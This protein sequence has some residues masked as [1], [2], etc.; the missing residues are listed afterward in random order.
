MLKSK[1]KDNISVTGYLPHHEMIDIIGTAKAMVLAANEDLGLTCLE[2]QSCG[3]PVIALKKGGY[4]ETV[5]EG[6]NGIFFEEQSINSILGA[7]QKFEG[8]GVEWTPQEIRESVLPYSDRIFRE[9]IKSFVDEK[10][11]VLHV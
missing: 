2:A 10:T 3:T 5:Q 9:K 4:L 6:K 8:K 7:V 1:A 11:G